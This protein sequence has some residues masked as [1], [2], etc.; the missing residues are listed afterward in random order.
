MNA[1]AAS[2]IAVLELHHV[3]QGGLEPTE[4]CLPLY[5]EC[6]DLKG[7]CRQFFPLIP[8]SLFSG[9]RRGSVSPTES[10]RPVATTVLH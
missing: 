2:I 8:V 10:C 9:L 6:W 3:D 5:A 1:R 4:T 7:C